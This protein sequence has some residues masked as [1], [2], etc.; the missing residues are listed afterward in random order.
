[1]RCLLPNNMM[2]KVT[3]IAKRAEEHL[4]QIGIL[5]KQRKVSIRVLDMPQVSIGLPDFPPSCEN[6]RLFQSVR[7][8]LAFETLWGDYASWKS[9]A[10]E[11]SRTCNKRHEEIRKSWRIEETE[12]TPYQQLAVNSIDMLRGRESSGKQLRV[13]SN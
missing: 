2:W 13:F 12:L 4:N 7:K 8:H 10:E 6:S 5:L 11:Y 1:M 9:K 3:D